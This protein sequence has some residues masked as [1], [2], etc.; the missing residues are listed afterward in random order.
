MTMEWRRLA[1]TLVVAATP[2]PTHKVT[3]GGPTPLAARQ[4]TRRARL[5]RHR[6]KKPAR[7]PATVAEATAGLGQKVAWQ[8]GGAPPVGRRRRR[9]LRGREWITHDAAVRC[10]CVSTVV[11]RTWRLVCHA[12]SHESPHHAEC[13]S[14]SN[15]ASSVVGSRLV[16]V[17]D[18]QDKA[19]WERRGVPRLS[20]ATQAS[21]CGRASAGGVPFAR[22][23]ART[24]ARCAR[25]VTLLAIVASVWTLLD[26]ACATCGQ[27]QSGTSATSAT[28]N[29]SASSWS[30][31][32]ARWPPRA[33]CR[34]GPGDWRR[35]P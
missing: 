3:P 13:V 27:V 17:P 31:A 25:M 26:H 28:E 4:L 9:G 11:N 2:T 19:L 6:P 14:T 12:W 34:T 16:R 7:P 30:R 22:H 20:V 1:A 10:T 15:W 35:A 24:A 5:V 23:A 18:L 29:D 8:Q 33:V 32:A 21:C